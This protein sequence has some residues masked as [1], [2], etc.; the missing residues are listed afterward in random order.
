LSTEPLISPARQDV[1]SVVE[2]TD[3][4]VR[5][6]QDL[7]SRAALDLEDAP[8]E[9]IMAWADSAFP[10]SFVVTCSMTDT[11]IA[12][13]VSRVV[14]HVPVL[15]LDTGY[16]FPETIDTLDR[17]KEAYGI[18]VLVAEPA[19]SVEKQ[20][21]TFGPRLHDRDPDLCCTMR[22]VIPLA[23]ALG[24][25]AAWGT[26]LRRADSPVRG[27]TPVVEWDT[28]RARVKVNPIARWSDGDVAAYT[29]SYGAIESPLLSDG[30]ASIGC[31]P[32]TR[33][34]R[35]GEDPRAG[36]WANSQKIEC[37]IHDLAGRTKVEVSQISLPS[38]K[39]HRSVS[40]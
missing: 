19:L 27:S 32:C 40:T 31:A 6:L 21:A 16:H 37:G 7:A 9:D 22:K 1:S 10:S 23:A 13:L 12:H 25:Y 20:D 24:P 2:L 39:E 3:G 26:G 30:Y 18:R 14:P 34:V 28:E 36:R 33:R 15:F 11:V 5:D 35:P 17:V 8:A 4:D 29:E 38:L